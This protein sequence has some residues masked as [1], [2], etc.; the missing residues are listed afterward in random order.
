MISDTLFEASEEV[1][2]YLADEVFALAYQP[3]PL[4]DRIEAMVAEM[5]T[6]RIILDTPPP[7]RADAE[8][9]G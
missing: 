9:I 7:S 1:K 8:L 3:G 6:I 5:D 4:R 2:R